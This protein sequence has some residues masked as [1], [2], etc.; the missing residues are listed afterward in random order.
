M[1]GMEGIAGKRILI[2]NDDGIDGPGIKLLESIAREFSDDVWVVAPDEER[3]GASQAISISHPIRYSQR[4]ERH[5]AVR[6]TPT[7][8]ALLGINVFLEGRKPD[9]LLSGINAGPN[10][11][12]DVHYSGTC[13]AAKEGALLGIPSFSLSQMRS[14]GVP[15]LWEASETHLPGIMGKLLGMDWLPGSFVN[16]NVPN[17]PAA[18]IAGVKVTRQG[19]RLPGGFLPVRRV[20]ERTVPYFWVK[21]SPN[22]PELVE[23]TDLHAV[24]H[25]A[26]SVTPMQL[27]LTHTRIAAEI[28]GMFGDADLTAA[29]VAGAEACI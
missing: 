9:I 18:Q 20:D 13:A 29:V 17:L 5:F 7:D 23:G 26:I 14:Y 22:A 15:T 16:I 21:I 28:A 27:D 8:C 6:G 11:A 24:A 4:D 12:E 25:G 1:S 3:S 2:V 19:Q 10:L